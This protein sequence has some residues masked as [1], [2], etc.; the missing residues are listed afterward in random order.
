M[1]ASLL[2]A[3][4]GVNP[5]ELYVTI[6]ARALSAL[7][8]FRFLVVPSPYAIATTRYFH[9]FPIPLTILTTGRFLFCGPPSHGAPPYPASKPAG[10]HCHGCVIEA[11]SRPWTSGARE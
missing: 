4:R 9:T 6:S 8:H 1:L 10:L 5:G 7:P 3:N 2:Q 11:I